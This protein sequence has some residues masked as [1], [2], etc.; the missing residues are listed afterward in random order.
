VTKRAHISSE[1]NRIMLQN[2]L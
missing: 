1:R 2:V